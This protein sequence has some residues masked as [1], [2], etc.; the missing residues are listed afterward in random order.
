M[1]MIAVPSLRAQ[2]AHQLEDLR[3]DGD[4]E[5]GG[6]LVGDQQPRVAGERHRDHHALAHAARELVRIVVGALLGRRDAHPAQHLDRLALRCLAP[7][8][9]RW[10]SSASAIWSPTVNAGLSEVIGSWKI[11]ASRSPRSS[12]SRAGGSFSRSSPSKQHLAAGDAPGR[13]RHQP[14]DATAR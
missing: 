3:L 11:I 2:R 9:P 4:V 6:R 10:R 13:L 12:R 7:L 14:H 8:T 1:R 5:R